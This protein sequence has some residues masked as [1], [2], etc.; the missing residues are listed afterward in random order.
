MAQKAT[1]SRW[2]SRWSPSRWSLRVWLVLGL[3][4]MLLWQ[5][6]SWWTDQRSD[7][8]RLVNQVWIER[9]PANERDMIWHLIAIQHED[10]RFGSLGRSS[11]WRVAADGFLWERKG[12]QFSFVTPQNG[13]RASLKTRIWKC[14]GEA[15]RPFEL[16]LELEGHGQKYRYYSRES[17]V[18]RPR[19]G[20]EPIAEEIRF[21][22]PALETAYGVTADAPADVAPAEGT[23]SPLNREE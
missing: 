2:F 12:D 10:H 22:A 8:E 7:S 18:I 6:G 16:C 4:G 1:S 9:V 15:P 17:W 14:A 19:T 21:L 5:A 3:G 23:C 11:R 13:C 20:D